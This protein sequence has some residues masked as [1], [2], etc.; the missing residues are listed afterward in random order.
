MS[1]LS[2]LATPYTAVDCSPH[3]GSLLRAKR[4]RWACK[5]AAKLMMEGKKIFCP[6]AHSH[7]IE[8][9]GMNGKNQSGE[10]WL[11]Q[12][13]A[14]L[15]NCKELLVFKMKG[16]ENS[17]GVAEEIAFAKANSIPVIYLENV[18]FPVTKPYR[19]RVPKD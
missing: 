12:D 15:K 13:F 18:R 8:L 11:K 19:K 3:Q 14:V 2:Y 1:N 7:P 9:H 10:W 16:W 5:M 6:I 4:F 17:K